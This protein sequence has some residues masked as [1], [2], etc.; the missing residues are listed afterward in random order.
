MVEN[1][2]HSPMFANSP[3]RSP[4]AIVPR[5]CICDATKASISRVNSSDLRRI[6]EESQKNCRGISG[7]FRQRSSAALLLLLLF[8]CHWVSEFC[9]RWVSLGGALFNRAPTKDLS[10]V[11]CVEFIGLH[12]HALRHLTTANWSLSFAFLPLRLSRHSAVVVV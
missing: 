11:C 8:Y 10:V 5:L 7:E 12:S 3:S 2:C 9:V 1:E 6:S 4:L